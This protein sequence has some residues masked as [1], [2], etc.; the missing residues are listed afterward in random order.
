MRCETPKTTYNGQTR[1][2]GYYELRVW[3]QDGKVYAAPSL[4]FHY[5][6]EHNYEPPKEFINAVMS[7]DDPDNEDYYNRLL[8]LEHGDAFYFEKDRTL[9]K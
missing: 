3:G 1:R 6:N 2:V 9:E 7:S 5:M 4:I 8:T